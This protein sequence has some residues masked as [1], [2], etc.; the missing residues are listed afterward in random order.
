MRCALLRKIRRDVIQFMQH[1]DR[2]KLRQANR[3]SAFRTRA[4]VF[5]GIEERD[6]SIVKMTRIIAAGLALSMAAGMTSSAWAA[7]VN[8]PKQDRG[9][10]TYLPGEGG[11]KDEMLHWSQPCGE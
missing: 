3:V 7:K 5:E 11:C 9:F 10:Q 4:N 2:R 1:D 6:M 8:P